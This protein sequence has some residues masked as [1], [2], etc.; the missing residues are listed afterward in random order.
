MDKITKYRFAKSA[1]LFLFFCAGLATNG[2]AQRPTLFGGN[3]SDSTRNR[4]SDTT[5][6]DSN[7]LAAANIAFSKDSLDAEVEYGAKDSLIFDNSHQLVYLYGAGFVHYRSLAL[8]ADYIIIDM[9]NN[10]ATA[11]PRTD[12]AGKVKGVPHFKDGAQDFTAQKMRYNF[13]TKK[14][15]VY[16]VTTTQSNVYIHGG[17]SKFVGGATD[18]T[19]AK[20]DTTKPT[21]IAYSADAIFTSCNAKNPHFGIQSAKQKIIPNKLIVVGPSNLMIGGIPTPLWLPFGF[22]PITKNKASGLIVPRDYEYRPDWGYGLQNLG[23]YIPINDHYDL[24]IST[25]LYV[26]GTYGVSLTSNYNT[27]YKNSGNVRVGFN[28]QVIEDEHART[29]RQRSYDFHW[30]HRQDA[31]AH[32]SMNYQASIGIQTNNFQRNT[33]RDYKSQTQNSLNSSANFTKSFPGKPYNFSASFAHSQNTA[34][35][36]MNVTLPNLNFTMQTISPFK[37]AKAVGNERWY[38]KITL[39]YNSEAQNSVK[40]TDTTIFQ[41]N[42]WQDA[43]MGVKHNASSSVSFRVLKYFNFTPSISY[44]ESWFFRSQNITFNPNITDTVQRR[45][46]NPNNPLDYTIQIDT[47][48]AGRVD[49]SIS[50]GFYRAYQFNTG[51]SLS[52]ILFGTLNFGKKSWLRTLRHTMTPSVSFGYSPDYSQYSNSVQRDYRIGRNQPVLYNRFDGAAYTAPTGVKQMSLNYSISNLFEAKYFSKR[53]SAEKKTHLLEAINLSGG[54]NF[55]V[56]SFRWSPAGF[57]TGT[58]LFKGLTTVSVNGSLDFYDMTANG[59]RSKTLLI[60]NKKFPARV[61]ALTVNASTSFSVGQL[62]DL[63]T[64]KLTSNEVQSSSA[65]AS[66][67]KTNGKSPQKILEEESLVDLVQNWR[68]NHNFGLALGTANGR[69]SF[70]TT[71]NRLST[72]GDIKISKNWRITVSNIGYDFV[73]KRLTFPQFGFYRDL[74]CWEM[75]ATWQPTTNTYQFFLRVKPG[76]FDFINLPYNKNGID[77]FK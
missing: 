46:I 42:V 34:T 56:D 62:R 29:N 66:Q 2:W 41:K 75:G 47:L 77:V 48:R 4:S 69:D 65:A 21:D 22:Y 9:K 18:T 13:R 30:S 14:G 63:L 43:R 6:I 64:G 20:G 50:R 5:A 1:L 70:R 40:A 51:V 28:D 33:Y 73:Q 8:T 52:T 19:L 60:T 26:K 61:T 54:Y 7:R 35:R 37:R 36:E 39:N 68:I 32:P 27:I 45:I 15:M 59:L 3:L 72:Q 57:S 76:T 24:T 25:N 55:A 58:N 16:D 71:D 10:I 67:E 74:H 38:E 12:T 11:E 23:Y 53:D 17:K 44:T 31:R 49:T